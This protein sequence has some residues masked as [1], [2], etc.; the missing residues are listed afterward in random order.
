[1]QENKKNFIYLLSLIVLIVLLF[2]LIRPEKINSMEFN[3]LDGEKLKSDDINK[4]LILNFW[5]T[6]CP[7]CIKEM[8]D[9]AKIHHEFKDDIELI[10]VAMPYDLPSRVINFKN[11]NALPFKVA[12]DPDNRILSEFEQVKLTPTTIVADKNKTIYQTIIGEINYENLKE[13]ILKLR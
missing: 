4:I 3:I 13:T 8:P 2:F 1:M 10:A 9:L 6:D 5:A 12:I 7:T 11:K